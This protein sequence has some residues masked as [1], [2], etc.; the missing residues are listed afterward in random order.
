MTAFVAAYDTEKSGEC[1]AACRAITRVHRDRGIPATF[2]VVGRLLEQERADCLDLLDEEGLF[3]AASHSYSHRLVRD[4]P[5]SGKAA[6]AET[7][8]HELVRSLELVEE[9]FGREC[10]G[11]RTPVGFTDGLSGAPE[12]V[13]EAADAGYRYISS[14][15]WGPHGTVPAPLEQAHTYADD[16]RPDLWEF[17]CHGWHENV[18]KGHDATPGRLLLWPPLYPQ[19]QLHRY[20]KTPEEEFEVHR[21]FVDRAVE[22]GLEYVSLVWHP[23]SLGRFDPEM[24]MLDLLFDYVAEQGLPFLRFEDLWRRR[25]GA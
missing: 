7:I 4:S 2:F 16:G 22:E 11:L 14:R 5:V 17:P 23:W 25:S 13:A 6:D 1:L 3:E 19:M 15:A 18:L 12:V 8:H 9:V 24:R 10:L 20:V 21:F